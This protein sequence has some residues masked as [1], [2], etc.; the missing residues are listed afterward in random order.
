MFRYIVS[1]RFHKDFDYKEFIEGVEHALL[2]ISQALS[3]GDISS[4]E[5]LFSKEAYKEIKENMKKYSR[6]ELTEFAVDKNNSLLAHLT[7]LDSISYYETGIQ[8]Y[9]QIC[10]LHMAPLLVVLD[11]TVCRCS[12]RICGNFSLLL[13]KRT[14]KHSKWCE[15]YS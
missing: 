9:T 6:D 15:S 3:Q 14:C 5:E 7:H 1:P 11:F 2:I 12:K 10:Q 8:L 13:F 4:V